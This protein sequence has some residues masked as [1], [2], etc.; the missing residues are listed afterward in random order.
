LSS[1]NAIPAPQYARNMKAIG[2]SDQGGRP[3]AVQVMVQRGYAYVGHLF[4]NGISVIDVR[5][6]RKPVAG[7]FIPAPPNTW[8]LHLQAHDDLLLVVNARDMKALPAFA[9]DKSYYIRE[10]IIIVPKNAVILNGTVI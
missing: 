8:N 6:P 10:G 5:D 1:D 2:H 4:S 3:D 9:D 7:E